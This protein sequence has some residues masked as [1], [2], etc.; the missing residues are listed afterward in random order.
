MSSSNRNYDYLPGDEAPFRRLRTRAP[1]GIGVAYSPENDERARAWPGDAKFPFAMQPPD[2]E[3]PQVYRDR[4]VAGPLPLVVLGTGPVDLAANYEV[5]PELDVR[6]SRLLVMYV[7]YAPSGASALSLVPQAGLQHK[8]SAEWY[9][10]GVV[11]PTLDVMTSVQPINYGFRNMVLSELRVP[12]SGAGDVA[13]V[14][15]SFDVSSFATF[16]LLVGDTAVADATLGLAVARM[17]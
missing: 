11:D 6:G 15:A 2:V 14:V 10:V 3:A 16:R 8:G 4:D 1:D 5:L 17:R 13:N 9:S 12:S 7:T